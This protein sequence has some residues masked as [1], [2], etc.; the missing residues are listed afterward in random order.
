[1][2]RITLAVAQFSSVWGKPDENLAA[3]VRLTEPAA[4]QGAA[5]VLFPEDCLSGYPSERG[6][7]AK[8]AIRE[9][10]DE[11]RK[12]LALAGRHK[13]V[14]AAGFIEQRGDVFHSAQAVAWP[15]GTRAIL[16]KQ[17]LDGRDRGIGLVVSEAPNPDMEVVGV[18]MALCI[19][20]DGTERFFNRAQQRGVDVILHPSG[21]ACVRSVFAG[22]P[23]ASE[24]EA[25]EHASCG[26]C[27]EATARRAKELG[28]VYCVSN[29]VGFDGERGY[30]GNSF[31]I[32][33][34]GEVLA[35]LPGTGIYEEMKEG[36]VTAAATVGQ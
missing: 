7:A 2:K 23:D 24:A 25:C 35:C 18:A 27:V 20:C 5:L 30:P 34:E 12:L 28:V 31:I 15:D 17:S 32:S 4:R 10:G 13:I 22:D 36:V 1:M 11:L 14:I 9:D 29:P 19:C 26:Q 8:V 6:S 3:I 16:R 33:R 21:G